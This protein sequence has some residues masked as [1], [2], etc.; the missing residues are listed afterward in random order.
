MGLPRR[1]FLKI[2]TLASFAAALQIQIPGLVLAQKATGK[3]PALLEDPFD[4]V[5][6][7]NRS[8]FTPLVKSDFLVH[9]KGGRSLR[10]SLVEVRDLPQAKRDDAKA[11][12]KEECF[13]LLFRG[14]GMEPLKQ[15]SYLVE[16]PR[17]GSF[18]LFLVPKDSNFAGRSYEAVFNRLNR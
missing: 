15:G 9:P 10:L 8:T 2:T 3:N 6:Y 7:F 12:D 18:V 5:G 1:R 13:S 17:L 11:D 4:A 16:H 14:A